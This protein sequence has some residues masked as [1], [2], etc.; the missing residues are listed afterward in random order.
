MPPAKAAHRIGVTEMRFKEF[1]AELLKYGFPLPDPV[2]GNF[3]LDAIDRYI[4]KRNPKLMGEQDD[5]EAI[6][7]EAE[8]LRR[9]KKLR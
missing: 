3:D 2:T 7:D 4:A 6:T 1:Y 5:G 8:M 9:I